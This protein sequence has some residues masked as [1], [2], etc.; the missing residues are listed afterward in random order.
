MEQ[1]R[2]LHKEYNRVP[3]TSRNRKLIV[4]YFATYLLSKYEYLD[5]CVMS[6]MVVQ[7][8]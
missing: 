2:E 8:V 7:I 1:C 3:R 4:T 5:A 6:R